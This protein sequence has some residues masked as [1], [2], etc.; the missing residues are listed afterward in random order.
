MFFGLVNN[1]RCYADVMDQVISRKV[2]LFQ[3][4]DLHRAVLPVNIKL[5]K[6]EQ[7]IS[8]EPTL[9]FRVCKA[10]FCISKRIAVLTSHLINVFFQ[11]RF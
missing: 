9:P 3:I 6:K 2:Y 1:R 4:S 10:L 8:V 11:E 7:P 5:S